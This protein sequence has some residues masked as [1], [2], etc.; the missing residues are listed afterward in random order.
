[1]T[2][3]PLRVF[4]STGEASGEVLA[5]DLIGAM[6][7]RGV[8]ID[9]DGIGGERLEAAGVR[10]TQRSAGWASMGPLDALGKIPALLAVATR[11]A[12]AL[13]RRSYDLI[14]LVDFGAFNL[15]LAGLIRLFGTSTPI[16]YYFPPG[17]W[18]DDA[19]RARR[20]AELCDP[21]TAFAHQRDFYRSLGLPIG[22]AGHPL[23]S[24]I[25][26]RPRRAPAPPDGG[27]IALLPG[28][29][30]GEIARHTPRLLNA[31]ALLRERRPAITAVLAAVDLAAYA[32]FEELL[33]LRSPLPVRLVRSAREALSG[34]DAAAVASGTAV[35]EAALLEVP[36]VAL[37]VLSD[38]QA[39]I[40]RRVYKRRFITLPNLV[41]DE[42]VVPELLQD[43]AT[44]RALADAL[45]HALAAPGEQL[46]GFRRL[47][48]ALGP[49][50]TLE[51]CARFALRLAA[52]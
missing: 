22:W 13:R 9:A 39:N 29:R 26:P 6:R 15:R 36:T 2:S 50:D 23:V 44:P 10:L 48:E 34:A 51:R 12:V 4:V 1:M 14:V 35:L 42:E 21:L 25:A 40:A 47:R 19:K 33:R 3:A 38:A 16:L 32:A 49:P 41:L 24:T 28:S 11:T 30:A 18:L 37:Y 46:G 27:V 20:V 43:A 45:E 31:L 7:N 5:A 52:R 17:A 8:A